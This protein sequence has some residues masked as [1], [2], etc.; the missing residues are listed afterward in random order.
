MKGTGTHLKIAKGI[1]LVGKKYK[2]VAF[3]TKT[4]SNVTYLTEVILSA[5]LLIEHQYLT[6]QSSDM[7]YNYR[8]I[9]LHSNWSKRINL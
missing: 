4:F 6:M 8:I 9:I 7:F 1:P 3:I 5:L 2:K